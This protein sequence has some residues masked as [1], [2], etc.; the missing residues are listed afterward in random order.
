MSIDDPAVYHSMS[1]EL[2]KVTKAE[3]LGRF[4][5]SVDHAFDNGVPLHAYVDSDTNLLMIEQKHV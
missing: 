2:D 3:H 5:L 4:S 1:L